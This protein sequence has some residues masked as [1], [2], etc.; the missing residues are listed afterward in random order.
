MSPVTATADNYIP[1]GSQDPTTFYTGATCPAGTVLTDGGTYVT[2][3][4]GPA[5][6]VSAGFSENP[7]NIR[8]L[9]SVHSDVPATTPITFTVYARCIPVS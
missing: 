3:G 1:V 9:G 7:P 2:S 5:V 4:A 8:W 6:H